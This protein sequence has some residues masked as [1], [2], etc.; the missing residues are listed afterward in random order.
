MARLGTALARRP[1]EDPANALGGRLADAFER[2]LARAVERRLAGAPSARRPGRFE[3]RVLAA[4]LLA[5]RELLRRLAALPEA[6]RAAIMLGLRG[7]RH[8]LPAGL[9]LLSRLLRALAAAVRRQAGRAAAT[10][11]AA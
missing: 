11:R 8:G 5:Y 7:L 1:D 4:L 9:R 6:Q 2:R 3:Q 10:R